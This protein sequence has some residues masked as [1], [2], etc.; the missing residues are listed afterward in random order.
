MKVVSR[1]I[2]PGKIGLLLSCVSLAAMLAPAD[3]QEAEAADAPAVQEIIVTAQKR[4]QNL[5]DVP[6]SMAVIGGEALTRNG[7]K[8]FTELK[9]YVPNFYAQP[10][11][12]NNA[13]FIRGIGS[14]P[15]NLAVEQTVGLFVD[16]IYGGH[17]RQFQAPFLDIERIEV[18]RGPQGALVGKNT[19]AGAISVISAKPTRDFMA[20][21]DGSAEFELGGGSVQG[22]VSGPLSDALAARIAVRYEKS[23]GYTRNSQLSGNEPKRQ[24]FFARGTLLY[25]A[26]RG[27][28]V[29]AKLEGGHVDI[30]GTAVERIQTAADPDRV[31]ATSGFPGFVD[32]DFDNT[33]SLNGSVT[34]NIDIGDHVLTSISGYSHYKFDKRLDSDFGPAPQLATGFGEKYDQFSQEVRIASPTDHR[35]EYVVGGYFQTSDYRLIGDTRIRV[36]AYNGGSYRRFDQDNIVWSGFG[37][38]TYKFSS[39]FRLIG[40]LRYTY[41][42]K[43]ADQERANT[44]AV[45]PSWIATPLS[46]RRVEKEWDPSAS[47]Q[48]EPSK[49]AMLYLSYGQ[50]SKSGGFV[51]AQSTTTAAQFQIEPESSETYEVGAKLALF[52]RKAFFNIALFHTEFKDLQVSSYDAVSA[53]FI[54]ANAGQATSKGVEADLSFPIL[55]TVKLTASAAYL[56]A[57]YDDFPGAPCFYDNPTCNPLNNNAAGKPVPLSSKWSGA[58][59]ADL[60]QPVTDRLH[61]LGN[62]GISFR[63]RTYLETSYNPAAAQNGF[64]KLDARIGLRDADRRWEVALV[65]KNLTNRTTSS[66]AFAVPFAASLLGKFVDPPRTIAAQFTLN[67]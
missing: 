31:R 29:I 30:T 52:N 22:V 17:A 1:I 16:G 10:S 34:V 51:G 41:D 12:G 15:G 40:S 44:G 25:D 59:N 36:G 53:S 37:Q 47:V 39:S 64:A 42:R 38:L 63:S 9:Q 56:D 3:A 21:I 11:P 28:E 5:Q 67:F 48:W 4:A 45:L 65:G 58:V 43:T 60:D 27:L 49:A 8:D 66:F 26:G 18:L 35:L 24:S 46:G 33:D 55:D 19:S 13:F 2:A 62:V 32:K 20:R 23:D 50:G 14:P 57:H 61:L 6:I 54:T 7:V